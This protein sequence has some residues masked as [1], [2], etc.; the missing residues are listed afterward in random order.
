ML[1]LEVSEISIRRQSNYPALQ[2]GSENQKLAIGEWL[3][4]LLTLVR[5]NKNV[6]R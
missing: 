3:L 5:Q 6:K 4:P 2:K 1:R